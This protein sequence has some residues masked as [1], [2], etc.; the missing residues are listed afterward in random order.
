MRELVQRQDIAVEAIV[1]RGCRAK[2]YAVFAK[3]RCARV[4]HAPE[5]KAGDQDDVVLRKRKR[6]LEVVSQ[7]V[8]AAR[9]DVLQLRDFRFRAP[10]LRLAHVH[11]GLVGRGVHVDP[12]AGGKG[13]KVGG[14][15]A[16][17][18]KRGVRLFAGDLHA[19][20]SRVAKDLPVPRSVDGERE[21]RL[22]VRLIKAWEGHVGVH[23]DEERVEILAAIFLVTVARDR[24][25]A[26]SDTRRKRKLDG[27]LPCT[28]LSG[29]QPQV[30]LGHG[31]LNLDPVEPDGLER[32][33]A[34]VEP[35]I[36]A[37]GGAGLNRKAQHFM[38]GHGCRV[39]PERK[40]ELVADLR[41]PRPSLGRQFPGNPRAGR[42]ALRRR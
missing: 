14:D 24:R 41:H 33:I 12:G 22:Q 1:G 20:W 21:T 9:C 30:A 39:F 42:A 26:R 3:K 6:L 17:L 29:G 16:G 36:A 8:H 7:P 23:G 15:G 11:V 40:I 19:G 2:Q 38:A 13:E 28:Q 31:G 25:A 37:A 4:L 10:N 18:V 35:K 32:A 5:G 27:V 34:E